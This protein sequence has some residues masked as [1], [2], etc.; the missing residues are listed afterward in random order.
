[1]KK[2]G[3]EIHLNNLK[4]EDEARE[5]FK[6]LFWKFYFYLNRK[7]NNDMKNIE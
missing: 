7:W 5:K 4:D 1:M 2:R 6:Q 3:F